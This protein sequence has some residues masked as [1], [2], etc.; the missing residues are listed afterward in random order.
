MTNDP[1]YDEMMEQAKQYAA[2]GGAKPLPGD[3]SPEA[4]FTRLSY[5]RRYLPD[6]K[7]YT[8]AVAGA[9]SL[10][11]VA[12]VSFRDPAARQKKTSGAHARP[13]GSALPTSQMV[14]TTS[15]APL[16]RACSGWI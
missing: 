10:L 16:R 11:R 12:Q 7:N 5:Y 14:F 2:F 13:I 1:P 6:P 8:E 3:N 15:T 9:L 4:R